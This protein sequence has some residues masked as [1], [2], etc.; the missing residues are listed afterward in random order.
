M[1]KIIVMTA[2]AVTAFG[3][4]ACNKNDSGNLKGQDDRARTT[5]VRMIVARMIVA[6]TIVARMTAVRTIGARTTVDHRA[7]APLAQLHA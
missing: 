6:R 5:A 2:M 7:A 4:A 1:R 3:L